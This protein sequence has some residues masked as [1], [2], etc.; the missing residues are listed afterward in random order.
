[1]LLPDVLVLPQLFRAQLTGTVPGQEA[2]IARR[3]PRGPT[4]AYIVWYVAGSAPG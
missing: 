2:S 4:E 1:G 3:G